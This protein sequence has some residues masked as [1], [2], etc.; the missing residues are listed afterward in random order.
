MDN[1]VYGIDLGT[2]NSS[3]AVFDNDEI[4][5]I[6]NLDGSEI[7]PSVVFFTGTDTDGND[8]T[9][10]GIQA[11][12]AAATSPDNVVQFVKRLMGKQGSAYNFRAPS[13]KEYTPEMISALILKKVCQDAE[14][15]NGGTPIQDV[16]ITVPAYF[17]DA[18]R[19]A[20]KQAGKIAGLNVLRVINEPTAAA[21][22]FGLDL[23]QKGKALVY[24]LGGG[25]FD[26][27]IMDIRDG[28]FDVVATGGDSQLGGINFDQKIMSLIIN[29]LNEQGCEIDDENDAL[30]SDI[31][32]KAEK[33]KIQLTGVEHSRPVFTING[34][35]YRI[36]ISR[37]E[38]ESESESLLQRTQFLL[39]EV[40]KDK[41]ISWADIDVLLAVGGSTKM[42]MVKKRL[43]QLSGKSVTYKV[44]PDTA[45]AQGAAIFASTL[46]AT[47]ET[48]D[49]NLPVPFNSV[50]GSIVISD[51]TSQSLGVVTVDGEFSNRK[52]NTIIIPNNTK[53]PAKKSQIVYTV[54][55]NQTQVLVEVT[56]GND[57]E[58]EFVK[59][60]GSST[61]KMPPYPKNSPI[62][63]IY[64]YDADQTIYIEVIDKVTN[65]SLGTFEIERNSNLSGE[66]VVDAT[67]IVSS[68]MVD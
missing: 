48:Q 27:T 28:E 55:D 59:I 14:Q 18:R 49:N 34:T 64:A 24:D 21:I 44:D 4:H 12:N 57:P 22:A 15:Y 32:E 29:K 67:G 30:M 9:L 13:G 37:D 19:I 45:V 8:E 46:N 47:A 60:I 2:T 40:M 31:R 38:F 56:E 51:V 53:I 54:V 35:T 26:V 36:D 7:T 25:T 62:E 52:Y 58:L 65:L 66:Q 33:T 42:P 11:K 20:T 68:A 1:K 50:A 61:L 23:T 10:V 17:D 41:N 16:V 39:E 63:I 6:K 3:I 43:E 5:I